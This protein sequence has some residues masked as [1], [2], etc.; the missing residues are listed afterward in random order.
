MNLNYML[1][2]K[3]A[4]WKKNKNNHEQLI[5]SFSLQNIDT[6]HQYLTTQARG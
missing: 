5:V 4:K 2:I 3:L 6:K 1:W